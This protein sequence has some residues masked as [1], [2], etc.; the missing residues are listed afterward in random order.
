MVDDANKDLLK[1]SQHIGIDVL[2][3]ITPFKCSFQDLICHNGVTDCPVPKNP[4][5]EMQPAFTWIFENRIRVSPLQDLQI[6]TR[7]VSRLKNYPG[8]VVYIR[9][10][11]RLSVHFSALL[12]KKSPTEYR[13]T[14][15]KF[16]KTLYI[17]EKYDIS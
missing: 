7:P 12:K 14:A 9:V 16:S 13:W 4:V 15:Q 5:W 6:R 2:H 10:L 8:V 11:A 17:V 3:T 1:Q